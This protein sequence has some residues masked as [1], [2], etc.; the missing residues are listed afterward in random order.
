MWVGHV[1]MMLDTRIHI[2]LLDLAFTIEPRLISGDPQGRRIRPWLGL[3]I[4]VLLVA[5]LALTGQAAIWAVHE[6]VPHRERTP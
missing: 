4:I 3:I 2:G 6:A 5:G 1:L